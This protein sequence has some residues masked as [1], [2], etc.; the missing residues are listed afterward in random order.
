MSKVHA[1]ALAVWTEGRRESWISWARARTRIPLRSERRWRAIASILSKR[2]EAAAVF[3]AT[4]GEIAA[5]QA[6]TIA[7]TRVR[8]LVLTATSCSDGCRA[9]D[10][11]S[12]KPDSRVK[13]RCVEAPADRVD[14]PS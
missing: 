1:E 10:R 13:A 3:A 2:V 5:M 11:F 7:V 9:N 12:S 8:D 14:E 4:A 6:T